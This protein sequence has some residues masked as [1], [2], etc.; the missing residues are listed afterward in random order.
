M[1]ISLGYPP[2]MAEK[3]ILSGGSRRREIYDIKPIFTLEQIDSI[4][5][6]IDKGVKASDMVIDYILDIAE[7]TRK[8]RFLR[9]GLSTRATLFMMRLGKANAYF[10][11]R[12]YVIPED[13][14]ELCTNIITHRVLFNDDF[15]SRDRD[16]LIRTLV[17]EVN[18]PA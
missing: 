7:A 10:N 14:K 4:R 8:S 6:E 18:M 15:P 9:A 12:D 5:T 3:I 17:D 11:G 13:V 1:K 2:R 16:A